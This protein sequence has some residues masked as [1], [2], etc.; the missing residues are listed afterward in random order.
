MVQNSGD[1]VS[2]HVTNVDRYAWINLQEYCL[3]RYGKIRGV[4]GEE[5][6]NAVTNYLR[7]SYKSNII[8]RQQ[9]T[10][11]KDMIRLISEHLF[12]SEVLEWPETKLIE[13]F[14]KLGL[15]DRRTHRKYL[16]LLQDQKEIKYK[17]TSPG[18]VKIYTIGRVEA[19][20]KHLQ[21]PPIEGDKP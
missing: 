1:Y 3:R 10:D 11:V 20:I 17:V 2:I 5:L 12:G 16:N 14:E 13:L 6:S 18:G 4:I 8:T 9:R 19:K 21:T 15:H 7:D